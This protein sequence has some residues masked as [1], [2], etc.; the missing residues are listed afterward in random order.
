MNQR[1]PFSAFIALALTMAGLT[2]CATPQP[3]VGMAA[4]VWQERNEV[5]GIALTELPKPDTVLAGNQGLLDLA[6]NA[7]M[8]ASLTEKVRTW[9]VSALKSS[10]QDIQQALEQQG[11]KTKVLDH[12]D[13]TGLKELSAKEGY[14]ELD[15]RPL[16]SKEG[17]DKLVLI[18]PVVAGT[19][20]TYYGMMPTSEPVAQVAVNS[21]VIDLDDN[22]L[23]HYQPLVNQRSA[24][25]EWDESPDYPALTNAFYQALDISQESL[26]VP[27]TQAPLTTSHQ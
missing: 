7:S 27:F 26:L 4:E 11:Y 13:I 6:V 15:Y 16:K 23:L 10:P 25:G 21:F 5:I 9:D 3:P 17:I 12:L 8:A 20:R 1:L 22:R 18:L 2:G 14:A 24:A 19:Y